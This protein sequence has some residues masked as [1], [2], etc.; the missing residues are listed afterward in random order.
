MGT[1]QTAVKQLALSTGFA[2]SC[3]SAICGDCQWLPTMGNG[4]AL[5]PV[6]LR[7]WHQNHRAGTS[8]VAWQVHGTRKACNKSCKN[9]TADLFCSSV[10]NTQAKL[11]SELPPMKILAALPF[12]LH[13]QLASW[14]LTLALKDGMTLRLVVPET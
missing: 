3:E 14:F 9:G 13:L 4:T 7:G 1:N 11:S 12:S 5:L 8:S 6:A 10:F 2:T